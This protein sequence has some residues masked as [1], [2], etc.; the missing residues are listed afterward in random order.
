MCL[1]T[2]HPLARGRARLILHLL[3]PRVLFFRINHHLREPRTHA[4]PTHTARREARVVH[5]DDLE[6]E[7][8]ERRQRAEPH[9]RERRGILPVHGRDERAAGRADVQHGVC[10]GQG[11]ECA[12]REMRYLRESVYQSDS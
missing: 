3:E 2:T 9:A 6:H 7:S 11:G 12:E 10:E 5:I 8:R 4:P 1:S